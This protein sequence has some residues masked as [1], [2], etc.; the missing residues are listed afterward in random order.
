MGKVI[1]FLCL[2]IVLYLSPKFGAYSDGSDLTGL[3]KCGLR[4]DIAVWCLS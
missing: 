3:S 4:Q 1:F 2:S